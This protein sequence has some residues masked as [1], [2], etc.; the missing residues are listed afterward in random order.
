MRGIGPTHRLC[1][2]KWQET[3]II[4]SRQVASPN[5]SS[6]PSSDMMKNFQLWNIGCPSWLSDNQCMRESFIYSHHVS[7]CRWHCRI[8]IWSSLDSQIQQLQEL[9]SMPYSKKR[10]LSRH[11]VKVKWKPCSNSLKCHDGSNKKEAST[12]NGT[13]HCRANWDWLYHLKS[14]EDYQY[15]IN[16]AKKFPHKV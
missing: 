14:R 10:G 16:D 2:A 13:C 9:I 5:R 11:W 6:Q 15:L 4:N 7:S 1:G 8:H 3:L 12:P